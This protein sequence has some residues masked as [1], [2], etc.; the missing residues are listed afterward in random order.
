MGDALSL[1][2]VHEDLLTQFA[3]TKPGKAMDG[4]AYTRPMRTREMSK[5]EMANFITAITAMMVDFEPVPEAL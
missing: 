4:K 3:P 2:A 5:E 1:D